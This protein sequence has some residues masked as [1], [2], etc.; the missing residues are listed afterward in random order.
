MRVT[1]AW[2]VE[3]DRSSRIFVVAPVPQVLM[4]M[5]ALMSSAYPEVVDGRC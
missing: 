4:R 3:Q 1:L 5:K 2:R